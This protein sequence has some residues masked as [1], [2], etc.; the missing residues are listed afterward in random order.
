MRDHAVDNLRRLVLT[1]FRPRVGPGHPEAE[2]HGA[3]GSASSEVQID[4]DTPR[5]GDVLLKS[6][7]EQTEGSKVLVLAEEF[8]GAPE[9][10]RG[11]VPGRDER[12][13]CIPA[14]RDVSVW[15]L[16]DHE[17]LPVAEFQGHLVRP[18]DMAQEDDLILIA[19]I[20][21]HGVVARHESG[22]GVGH[23]RRPRMAAN[24]TPDLL[25]R[26]EDEVRCVPHESHFYWIRLAT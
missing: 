14:R 15:P 17:E 19:L 13:R 7:H 9:M 11:V 25:V 10:G 18:A 26:V 6:V 3:Q 5:V 1:V 2:S 4:V 22:S 24:Q 23:D 21:Q 12:A 16:N 20:E 8:R